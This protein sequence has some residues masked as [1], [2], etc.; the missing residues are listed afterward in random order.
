MEPLHPYRPAARRA[1]DPKL[2]QEDH[3]RRALRR[4]LPARGGA[5]DTSAGLKKA[6][7]RARLQAGE[8]SLDI[9]GMRDR[10]AQ[11]SLVHRLSGAKG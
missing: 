10:L 3:L 5:S 2:G 7:T 8:L 11:N 4:R 6:A 9:C 1:G